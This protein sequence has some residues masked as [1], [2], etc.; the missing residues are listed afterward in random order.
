MISWL[1]LCG[2]GVAQAQAR[3]AFLPLRDVT[4]TYLLAAPG[5]PDND[6]SLAYDADDQLARI[7]D[8]AHGVYVLID[9]PARNAEVVVAA[10]H[11]MVTAPDL[12]A[13]SGEVYS[14]DDARFTPLGSARYAGAACENYLIIAKAGTATACITPDGVTLHFRGQDTHGAATVTATSVAYGALPASDFAPPAGFGTISLPPGA[15]AQ[16]LG[17]P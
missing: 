1:G 13:L 5:Q 6:Y 16:L 11:S 7:D 9:L 10:L 8:P 3:P 12:S 4:V 14:A 17:E 15:L 2:L